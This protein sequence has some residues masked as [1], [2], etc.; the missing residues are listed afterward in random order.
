MI[1]CFDGLV[2]SWS[3]RASPNGK[4]GNAVLDEA[5]SMPTPSN[6][7]VVH[8]GG[9][10]YRWPGWLHRLEATNLTRY[11]PRKEY[12]PANTAC[13]SFLGRLRTAF[14]YAWQ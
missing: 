10:H 6:H 3:I 12:T 7:T 4:L 8:S 14:F 9:C 2:F 11:I 5:I 1:D 13:E